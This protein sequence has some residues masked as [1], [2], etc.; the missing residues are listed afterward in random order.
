[1]DHALQTISYI[2]DIDDILVVMAHQGLVATSLDGAAMGGAPGGGTAGSVATGGAATGG[3][4]VGE[5]QTSSLRRK[6]QVHICCHVFQSDEV[7]LSLSLN[8][9]FIKYESTIRI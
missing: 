9:I 4:A 6:R 3:V 7:C 5:D 2:A 1:M 8:C